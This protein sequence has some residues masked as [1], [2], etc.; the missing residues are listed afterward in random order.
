MGALFSDSSVIV[1]KMTFSPNG[2]CYCFVLY[3]GHAILFAKGN[4]SCYLVLC[5]DLAVFN[6]KILTPLENLAGFFSV[7]IIFVFRLSFE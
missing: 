4:Y 2:F 6:K 5:F 1:Y 3:H 7:Y